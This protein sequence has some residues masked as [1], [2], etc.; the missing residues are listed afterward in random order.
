MRT[1][2]L[3]IGRRGNESTEDPIFTGKGGASIRQK[4]VTGMKGGKT[5]VQSTKKSALYE[6]NDKRVEN[7]IL[8]LGRGSPLWVVRKT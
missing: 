3:I 6:I 5:L 1:C 2:R 4:G 7:I 8:P